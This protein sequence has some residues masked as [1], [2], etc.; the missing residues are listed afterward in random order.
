MRSSCSLNTGNRRIQRSSALCGLQCLWRAW[1][2]NDSEARRRCRS[3]KGLIPDCVQRTS[4]LQEPTAL[5]STTISLD[6]Y[7]A[8]PYSQLRLTRHFPTQT[9]LLTAKTLYLVNLWPSS[10]HSMIESKIRITAGSTEPVSAWSKTIYLEPMVPALQLKVSDTLAATAPSVR[11]RSA[12]LSWHV[13]DIAVSTDRTEDEK[14]MRVRG[15]RTGL[16]ALADIDHD[17]RNLVSL[18]TNGKKQDGSRIP[19]LL[20]ESQHERRKRLSPF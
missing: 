2:R 8:D 20:A 3:T 16:W 10:L 13:F 18:T 15:R 9:M 14:H 6:V 7:I 1:F 11:C 5:C 12:F 17:L 4:V 19:Q